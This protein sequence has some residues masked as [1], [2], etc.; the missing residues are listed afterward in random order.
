MIAAKSGKGFVACLPFQV[1]ANYKD[2]ANQGHAML[3]VGALTG[4]LQWRPRLDVR[5]TPMIEVTSRRDL[6][7]KFEWIS[8]YNHSGHL[9]N[10]F[11]PPIPVRDVAINL[12][13]DRPIRK[14]STLVAG[15][16]LES[17]QDKTGAVEITV[18]EVEMYE[19]VLVEYEPGN[20]SN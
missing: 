4:G 16:R 11:H 13:S 18:P 1:G 10:A 8:L 2:W 19:I 5:T 17:A 9:A 15:E 12:K 20:E 14:V 6:D 7:G 3:A